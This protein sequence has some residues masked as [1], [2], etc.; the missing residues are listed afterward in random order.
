MDNNDPTNVDNHLLAR[1]NALKTSRSSLD[2]SRPT[3]DDNPS[4]SKHASKQQDEDLTKRFQRLTGSKNTLTK[5]QSPFLPPEK[6]FTLDED[7]GKTVEEILAEL[8]PEDQW[9]LD[10]DDSNEIQKLLDEARSALPATPNV[11]K[12]NS[13]TASGA[14]TDDT[15]APASKTASPSPPSPNSDSAIIAELDAP[16]T[17]DQEAALYLQ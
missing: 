10:P 8:G 3:F 16:L 1:L 14:P 9:T 7:D 11:L 15:T 2:P 4:S 12:E 17:E 5:P 13:H 6:E